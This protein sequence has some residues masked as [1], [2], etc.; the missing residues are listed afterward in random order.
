MC[1]RDS[2]G[3]YDAAVAQIRAKLEECFARQRGCRTLRQQLASAQ[4]HEDKVAAAAK[5]DA[6]AL[7]G[8]RAQAAQLQ[9]DIELQAAKA[10]KSAQDLEAAKAEVRALAVQRA[11]EAATRNAA[12]AIRLASW[13][14]SGRDWP[15]CRPC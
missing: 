7:A 8:M 15:T 11:A 4:S 13:P 1:I 10:D 9:K 5:A 6:D 14:P 12:A 3:G 2:L